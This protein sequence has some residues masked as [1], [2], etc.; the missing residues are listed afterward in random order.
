MVNLRKE[1]NPYRSFLEKAMEDMRQD[2]VGSAYS[3]KYWID[4]RFYITAFLHERG[5]NV[6]LCGIRAYNAV[7]VIQWLMR[8]AGQ[9][10]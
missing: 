5:K 7:E 1:F 4:S 2:F 6:P 9:R 3:F 8:H 10:K